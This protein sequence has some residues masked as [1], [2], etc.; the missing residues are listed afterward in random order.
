MS[1]FKCVT[2][3]KKANV[4]FD[5]GVTSRTILFADGSKKTLGIMQPGE[6]E[7]NTKD[8]EIME[9]LAGD[10]D[11]LLPGATQWKQFRAGDAFN[12]PAN[13]T[14]KLKVRELSD[15]CCSFIK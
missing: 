5:G 6:Y 12:V 9:I 10:M 4:F 11:V 14:F 8:A 7:F 1:E 13:S 3:I 15:Y 2:V